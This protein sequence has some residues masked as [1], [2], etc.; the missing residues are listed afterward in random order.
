M[1]TASHQEF[2]LL[3]SG[4]VAGHPVQIHQIRQHAVTEHRELRGAGRQS[5]A[6]ENTRGIAGGVQLA[7]QEFHR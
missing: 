4:G 5:V 6:Q 7:K 1:L 3:V 2:L